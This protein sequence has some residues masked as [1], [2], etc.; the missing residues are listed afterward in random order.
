MIYSVS[1]E[2]LNSAYD[3]NGNALQSVYGVDGGE[4]TFGVPTVTPLTWDMP[5]DYKNQILDTLDEIET[6]QNEHE[7]SYSICQFNDVHLGFSGNEPNF[8]DYNGGYNIIS[9]MLFVGDMVDM[10][11]SDPIQ[12]T[13]AIAYMSGAQA[14]KRIVCIGNHE[15]GSSYNPADGNPEILYNAL[16]DKISAHYMRDDVII[17]YSDN[18]VNNVRYIILN[19]FY[20]TQ[21][22]DE[23]DH[24]L[25]DAQISWCASAMESAGDRDIIIVCHTVMNPFELLA[26]QEEVTSSPLQGQDKLVNLITA[27]KNRWTYSI[28][29]NNVTHNYDFSRCT[30]DFIM[31]TSGHYHIAGY[32]NK[33]GFNMITCPAR[34]VR[35]AG[36]IRGITFY[37]IDPTLKKIKMIICSLDDDRS[38]YEF[39][40]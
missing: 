8:I 21:K 19:P 6:Y 12:Y 30:G 14:S 26:T 37:I 20:I 11:T 32:F 13:N 15:Y 39:T 23:H 5:D 29:V 25:D 40:Y 22:K 34:I 31:Y 33:N 17:F 18:N 28:S 3:K 7:G 35:T 16:N 38:T 9:R 2:Q 1:G 27:Y 4:Y 10:Y 24:L 36:L